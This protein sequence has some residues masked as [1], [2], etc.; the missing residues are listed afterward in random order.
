MLG[1]IYV[2]NMGTKIPVAAKLFHSHP[3]C[4]PSKL[5]FIYSP[6]KYLRTLY[7]AFYRFCDQHKGPQGV[8]RHKKKEK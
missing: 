3:I 6:I 7:W 1:I 4:D 8:H 5:I 2:R